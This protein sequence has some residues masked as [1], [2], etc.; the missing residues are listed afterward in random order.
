MTAVVAHRGARLAERENTVAAFER[1]VA[2]GAEWI[3]LDVRR[4]HDDVLVIHHDAHLPDGRLI[5]E[6]T[7]EALPDWVPTL[8]EA[9][10][11]CQGAAV[12]IEIKNDPAE[13]DYDAEHMISAAVAGTALAY[14]PA[15]EL[16]ISSF[17][18]DSILRIR[19]QEPSLP[20]AL[21]VALD[22]MDINMWVERLTHE[23][24]AAFHPSLHVVS[25]G[26]VEKCHAAGI[27]V[28]VWTVNE[29]E[30]M[31]RLIDWEVDGIITDDPELARQ[32]VDGRI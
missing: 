11:A 1:A 28:N 31:E 3:E 8:A 17:N 30:D 29:R 2:V 20:T 19:D 14:R 25:P 12:N 15:E 26:L 23:G 10:E 16:L 27:A 32:V 5:R 21:V 13:P 18:R 22:L 4:T 7:A 9:L 24:H 6:A